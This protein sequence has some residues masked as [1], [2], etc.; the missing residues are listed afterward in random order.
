MHSGWLRTYET[1]SVDIDTASAAGCAADFG[2]CVSLDQYKTRTGCEPPALW[3]LFQNDKDAAHH[4]TCLAAAAM[5]QEH[6]AARGIVEASAVGH[7]CNLGKKPVGK[8]GLYGGGRSR[9]STSVYPPA[10]P[11]A[12]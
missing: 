9:P 11:L 4:P 8:R 2:R 1:L 7:S 6:R 12:L 3:A 10:W 5:A